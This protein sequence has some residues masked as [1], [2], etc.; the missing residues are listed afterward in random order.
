MIY[1]SGISMTT[2]LELSVMK[3]AQNYVVKNTCYTSQASVIG[4]RG[5]RKA[6]AALSPNIVL[7]PQGNCSELSRGASTPW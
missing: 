5:K 7:L 4:R 3:L 6:W 1:C 2:I